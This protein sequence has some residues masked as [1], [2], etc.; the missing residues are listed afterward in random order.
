M[1]FPEKEN[2][3]VPSRLT[4]RRNR[5]VTRRRRRTQRRAETTGNTV[6][7]LKRGWFQYTKSGSANPQSTASTP[8][9]NVV[10]VACRLSLVL[11]PAPLLLLPYSC[12]SLS[13]F[14]L[15]FHSFFSP[16]FLSALVEC[17]LIVHGGAHLFTFLKLF[18]LMR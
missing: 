10:V 15:S 16:F 8:L 2:R 13:S 3:V 7:T 6:R 14:F 4:R 17:L 5:D 18:N 11:P 1:S 12:S 9:F